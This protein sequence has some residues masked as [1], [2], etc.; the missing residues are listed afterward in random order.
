MNTMNTFIQGMHIGDLSTSI[1]IEL[2]R[3]R[4]LKH[5]LFDITTDNRYRWE[6]TR[7]NFPRT[8]S[9]YNIQRKLGETNIPYKRFFDGGL[10]S[11]YNVDGL[12]VGWAYTTDFNKTRLSRGYASS[13]DFDELQ[14]LLRDNAISKKS[15]STSFYKNEESYGVDLTN[16]KT[17]IVTLKESTDDLYKSIN[18]IK[19]NK[20]SL[21]VFKGNGVTTNYFFDEPSF[22]SGNGSFNISTS[23]ADDN[24][25]GR[26]TFEGTSN[27]SRLLTY[28]EKLFKN[29][30]INTIINRFSSKPKNDDIENN[31]L[32]TAISKHGISRGRNLL[33]KGDSDNTSGY[34]NPYCRVWTAFHQYGTMKDRIRPFIDENGN[35]YSVMDVQNLLPESMRPNEG[36]KRL[37]ENTVLGNNGFVKI[38]PTAESVANNIKN[39][40]FSI[41]NLAWKDNNLSLSE[42]QRGPNNGRIMWFPPYNLKFS[43]NINVNWN[44]NSFIGRGEQIYTYVNTERSGTLDFSILIDH[45]SIINEWR[46]SA[47]DWEEDKENKKNELLRFFAGCEMLNFDK[48]YIATQ[49]VKIKKPN[50]EGGNTTAIPGREGKQKALIIYFPNNYTGFDR[51]DDV[52]KI[53]DD[54]FSYEIRSEEDF[55]NKELGRDVDKKYREQ[56][57]NDK[58][59]INKSSHS[60]FNNPSADTIKKIQQQMEEKLKSKNLDVMFL[61]NSFFFNGVSYNSIM[62]IFSE[63][64]IENKK[65]TIEYWGTASS[66]GNPKDNEYIS[67]KRAETMK[68]ICEEF[69]PQLKNSE[70]SFEIKSSV[71]PVSDIDNQKSINKDDAKLARYGLA[72]FNIIDNKDMIPENGRNNENI[73]VNGAVVDNNINTK[74]QNEERK[75]IESAYTITNEQKSYDNEYRYFTEISKN[76]K[77]VKHLVNKV[78]Y[79]DPAYHSITPE[80]FNA[81]LTFLQQCTRQGPT[82]SVSGGKVNSGS[83]N[84]LKYAGNLSFGRAPYCILRIGDFFNTKICIDSISI[85]YDNGDG[86]QWDLNPEGAGVQPMMANIS[87]NF[88]FIGGQDISGPI[89][90]LQNAVTSNYYANTSVYDK[91]ADY[92][93]KMNNS[94]TS[95][96]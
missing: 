76:D 85:N 44:G 45:P 64:E 27:V 40:M 71:I 96:Q 67:R 21:I 61:G 10:V 75:Y 55:E 22:F 62:D 51:K 84:Y 11:A 90:R 79:F 32:I 72:V 25:V 81:R 39:Y 60:Q 9:Y 4:S 83:G 31:D 1:F 18:I 14:K 46:G 43:E 17:D 28:T 49:K 3:N 77:F 34:D 12:E 91:K 2:S 80:G 15:K 94:K 30:K 13:S 65:I 16:L 26:R 88:K 19:Y 50:N 74:K 38:T 78:K 24:E 20:G 58:N 70:I 56:I 54:L 69:I 52:N 63:D 37:G 8:A 68:K 42:E 6:N 53:I 57:L 35:E 29:N 59:K 36:H 23:T 73:S 7:N 92:E 66:H 82:A 87:M 41:E 86:T 93:G 5:G 47:G 95:K 33:R 48:D 89:E